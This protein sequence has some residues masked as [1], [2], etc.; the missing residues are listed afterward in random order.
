M[1]GPPSDRAWRIP[2]LRIETWGTRGL[3]G[4]VKEKQTQIL[5]CAE[6]DNGRWR[7]FVQE[8]HRLLQAGVH[9]IEGAGDFGDFVV[10]ADG[11]LVE[12]HLALADAVG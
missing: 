2:C 10:A 11:E 5:R 12:V 4:W 9:S 6:D 7:L 1:D 3:G 8:V